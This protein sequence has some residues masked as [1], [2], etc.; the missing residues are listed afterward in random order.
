[1][2]PSFLFARP[3]RRTPAAV[4][5]RLLRAS[6]RTLSA[7]LREE[8]HRRTSPCLRPSLLAPLPLSP[9][10]ALT[11]TAR[12]SRHLTSPHLHTTRV[13]MRVSVLVCVHTD[14]CPCADVSLRV[15]VCVC[16]CVHTAAVRTPRLPF[17]GSP[18]L[19]PPLTPPPFVKP[20]S[21][22]QSC[23]TQTNNEKEKKGDAGVRVESLTRVIQRRKPCTSSFRE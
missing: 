13:C 19:Y 17:P 15:R 9:L 2:C 16:L 22:H 8:A 11:S 1:M 4:F 21:T 18:R 6:S 3:L 10:R 14:V 5:Q 20:L 23:E 12:P 7:A